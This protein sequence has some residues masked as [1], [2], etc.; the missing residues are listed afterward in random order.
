MIPLFRITFKSMD[1]SEMVENWIRKEAE[2]LETYYSPIMACHVAV[3][4]PHR[5]H[6]NG[7]RYHIRIHLK[8]RHGELVVKR[9]PTLSTRLRQLG[10]T[11]STKQVELDAAHKNLRQAIHD[12]F[13]AAGRRLRDYAQRRNGRVKIHETL[14][15]GKVSRLLPE[16]GHGFLMTPDGR[17]IYFHQNSVLNRAFPRMAIGTRVAFSEEAGEKGAQAS[18]VR[19]LGKRGIRHAPQLEAA[20]AD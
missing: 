10:E 19:I 4:I 9:E 2:K 20:L 18:T 6:K 12:A 5:H 8:L 13:N 7:A 3:E 17:E 16:E 15:E 14:A 11:E 1:S